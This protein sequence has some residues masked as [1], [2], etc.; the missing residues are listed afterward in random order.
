MEKK[1]IEYLQETMDKS[2]EW[3]ETAG[4]LLLVTKD[5]KEECFLK[6][7]YADIE[8]KK[9]LERNSL[10]RLYSMSKPVTAV[11]AMILLERGQIDLMDQ[12][13]YIFPSFNNMKVVEN[14]VPSRAARDVNLFDTFK[15]DRD[16][17]KD[18]ENKKYKEQ[19]SDFEKQKL[20]ELSGN[21]VDVSKITSLENIIK[22]SEMK[23]R[24][25]K[26][27]A[28]L[29]H[30]YEKDYSEKIA[31][32]QEW[33]LEL[34][35]LQSKASRLQQEGEDEKKEQGIKLSSAKDEDD[36]LKNAINTINSGFEEYEKEKRIL[37]YADSDS[38]VEQKE[39][40]MSVI[41]LLN[42]YKDVRENKSVYMLGMKKKI[43]SF[44][45]F[46][47]ANVFNLPTEFTIDEEYIRYA[48]TLIEIISFNTIK[49]YCDGKKDNYIKTLQGIRMSMDG[50][51]IEMEKV[52]RIISDI[53]REFKNARLPEV[54]QEIRVRHADMRDELYD[55]L[56]CIKEF[57]RINEGVDEESR[58]DH[59]IVFKK[60]LGIP[61]YA[62]HYPD[63]GGKYIWRSLVPHSKT[64]TDSEIY[65]KPFANGAHYRHVGI[66]FF[67][68][69]QDPYGYYELNTK[70]DLST[71]ET[72]K[73]QNF[74]KYGN[75]NERIYYNDAIDFGI[76][77]I[78]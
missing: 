35:E 26:K 16:N 25:L 71:G 54:V 36:R 42:R 51:D 59:F 49:V 75:G 7:G 66:N 39:T 64:N 65:D 3:G 30:D 12:L 28:L 23:I 58:P 77:D 68:R 53:D 55:C 5:G 70:T 62:I 69:R 43:K 22:A 52:K 50:L 41:E 4:S 40:T 67:L 60:T 73:L 44:K 47:K 29:I 18:V 61:K 37:S 9:P 48:K 20:D 72:N 34:Q 45:I 15:K 17:E 11:A 19:R 8:N 6:T 21:G 38:N 56:I 13:K 63:T 46:F 27:K 57:M 24:E 33:G 76:I 78:C 32:E 74:M 31:Y 1:K 2:V 14:G 10:F